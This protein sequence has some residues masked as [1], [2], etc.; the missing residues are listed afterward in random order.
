MCHWTHVLG[1]PGLRTEHA[2]GGESSQVV[3]GGNSPGAFVH[4]LLGTVLDF[5]FF[6]FFSSPT[7]TAITWPLL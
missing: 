2:L 6:S 7:E 3:T 4:D 5:F 1:Q